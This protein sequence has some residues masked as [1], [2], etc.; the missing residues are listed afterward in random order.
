MGPATP[1]FVVQNSRDMRSLRHDLPAVPTALL[2]QFASG[3]GPKQPSRRTRARH[4]KKAALTATVLDHF[5]GSPNATN[6]SLNPFRQ[7][8]SSRNVIVPPAWAT[9]LSHISPLPQPRASVRYFF[10]PPWL[11]DALVN[12]ETNPAKTA[13][14]LHHWI[15]IHTFC[16]IRL[17]DKTVVGRPLT[18][19]EWRDALWGDYVVDEIA[20]GGS[21]PLRGRTRTRHELQDRG[22]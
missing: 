9:A 6:Q 18:V 13:R 2:S 14:Y 7:F 10:P 22:M 19:S 1:M 3:P 11:L 15:S 5:P 8:Y 12:F 20:L 16:R 17:F 21:Q 4:A